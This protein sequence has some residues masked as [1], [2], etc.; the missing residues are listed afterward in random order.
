M[1]K[2]ISPHGIPELR[3]A[4]EFLSLEQGLTRTDL[5][6]QVGISVGY[7]NGF[8]RGRK[9]PRNEIKAR[10]INSFPLRDAQRRHLFELA[11]PSQHL[12][13]TD[14]LHRCITK[15]GAQD[16][17]ADLDAYGYVGLYLDPLRNILCGN[18]SFHQ[19]VPG[20]AAVDHN[21]V[22]WMFSPEARRLVVNWPDEARLAVI[23]LRSSLGRFRDDPRARE[24]FETLMRDRDFARLWKSTTMQVAYGRDIP[25]PMLVHTPDATEPQPLDLEISQYNGCEYVIF[26]NGGYETVDT[27]TR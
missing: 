24:L 20:L 9:H 27:A 4:V 5:A 18:E 19:L 12:P 22:R 17:L 26:A 6:R 11:Q 8:I 2:P 13:P 10:V 15:L 25:T 23:I 14:E 7:L 1:R 21:Y 3:K 16:H